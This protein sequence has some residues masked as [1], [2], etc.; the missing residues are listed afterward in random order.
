VQQ[1]KLLGDKRFPS[2][3]QWSNSTQLVQPRVQLRLGFC[4][5]ELHSPDADIVGRFDPQSYA[6]TFDFQYRDRDHSIT[7]FNFLLQSTR[8]N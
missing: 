2:P 5:F 4:H 6:T 7:D 3:F 1:L 8:K